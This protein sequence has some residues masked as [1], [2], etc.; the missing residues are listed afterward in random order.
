MDYE[1]IRKRFEDV[2][3]RNKDEYENCRKTVTKDI[4]LFIKEQKIIAQDQD[5]NLLIVNTP[6]S[7]V[8]DKDHFFSKFIRNG[9]I[10]S[11]EVNDQWSD[12]DYECKLRE[13][14]T[15]L[16]GIRILCYFKED[17]KRIYEALEKRLNENDLY[18]DFTPDPVNKKIIGR[19]EHS[20]YFYK[21]QGKVIY[22]DKEFCTEIQLKS[23]SNDLWSEVDHEIVYKAQQYQFDDSFTK[24]VSNNI[25][26]SVIASDRQLYELLNHTYKK[27]EVINSLF[28]LET[29]IE[30]FDGKYNDKANKLYHM[31]FDFY[32]TSEQNSLIK[33]YV[34]K[35]LLDEKYEKE[36]WSNSKIHEI[37]YF[38]KEFTEKYFLEKLLR[39]KPVASILYNY[40]DDYSF[41]NHISFLLLDK[42]ITKNTTDEETG[43]FTQNNSNDQKLDLIEFEK[44]IDDLLVNDELKKKYKRIFEGVSEAHDFN[45][46]SFTQKQNLKVAFVQLVTKLHEE[47]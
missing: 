42:L 45:R 41:L 38:T 12:S 37:N 39:I 19:R 30:V 20:V 23:M 9:Y 10:E 47:K 17:E 7:R 28:F 8:K 40:S 22:N 13:K 27:K 14:L 25:H 5:Y 18:K 15:D 6:E 32:S 33:K 3:E 11:W 31:F 29:E 4:E 26:D 24:E 46:M 43:D 44:E 16:I 2:F 21:T 1:N 35:K 34:A 36:L